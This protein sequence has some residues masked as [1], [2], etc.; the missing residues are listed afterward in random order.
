M[1]SAKAALKA[2]KAA[3]ENSSFHEAEV[4]SR[5]VLN[6]D[7]QNY[8]ATVFLGRAL[9][10]QVKLQ[11]ATEAYECATRIKPGDELAWK[12]LC[13]A[14]ESQGS[15]NVDRHT[16]ASMSLARIY[17]QNE[18]T[19][20]CQTVINHIVSVAQEHGTRQQ[21]KEALR[22]NLPASPV[23]N[24]LEG[25]IPHPSHTF[26]RLIEITEADEKDI[27]NREVGERRTR[28]GAKLGQVQLDV[29]REV[30]RKSELED[31]YQSVIDWTVDD[32]MRSQYEEKLLVH[33]YDFMTVL[34]ADDKTVKQKQ[35]QELARGMVVIKRPFKLAW[36]IELEW[37]DSEE[38]SGLDRNIL[39]E[40]ISFF[41]TTGIA[42][43]LQGFLSQK[44]V[45]K[46]TKEA[47]RDVHESPFQKLNDEEGLL[48][49]DEGISE[50]AKSAF[51]HRLVAEFYLRIEEY[52]SCLDI[53]R[54]G[55][56]LLHSEFEKCGK[57][58]QNSFDSICS[59]LGTSLVYH[60]APK[61]HPEARTIF[62]E[63]LKRKPNHTAALLGIGLIF[64]E[65]EDFD[66]A[67]SFLDRAL[68]RDPLNIRVEVEAA[69]CTALNGQL[70]DGLE[71]LEECNAKLQN[72][73]SSPRD[74]RAQ[75]SYRIGKCLW[76]LHSDRASRK[77]RHGPYS[78]FIASIRANSSYAPAYTSLGLYYKDYG[79]D[80]KRARQCF[81][82]AFESSA[83]ETT[84]AEQ[85]ACT[86]ANDADWDIV[87]IIAQ[88]VIDSGA[89]K[90]MP[91]SR[92]KP[93]SWP[94]AALGI[95]QMNKQEYPLAVRSYQ[96]ALRISPADYHSWVGLGE[97]YLSSGR[98]HAASKALEH[99]RNMEKGDHQSS[100][101]WLASYMHANVHKELGDYAEAIQGYEHIL[102]SQPEDFGV[103][104]ALL[105]TLV[106]EA[107]QALSKGFFHNAASSAKDALLLAADLVQKS[108]K[109]FNF[110]K[111]IGDAFSI[112]M[113]IP[114]LAVEMPLNSCR[115]I[116]HEVAMDDN[117]YLNEL[118][119]IDGISINSLTGPSEETQQFDILSTCL[120]ASIAA[121]KLGICAGAH[122]PHAQAVAWYNLGWAEHQA[123]RFTD[124]I[125]KVK[126]YSQFK[127]CS[128]SAIRCFKRA[129]E[130]EAS[131]AEFWNALGVV[132]TPLN[133]K[134]AQHS[135]V[136]SLHLNERSARTWTDLGTLYLTL[137]DRELAHQAFSRAQSTDPDYIYAWLGEGLVALQLDDAAEARSHFVHAFEIADASAVAAK[138][139][140][141]STLFDQ[142]FA[143]EISRSLG[144]IVTPIFAL[145]QLQ[146]QTEVL[147]PYRHLLS[148]LLERAADYQNAVEHLK[149][150]SDQIET[151]YEESES[152]GV[153]SQFIRLKSDLARNQLAMND[154][155]AASEN[156]HTA[157]DLS[158]DQDET[159]FSTDVRKTT[160]LSAHLTAGMASFYLGS[161]DDAITMFRA[162][163]EESG[164]D[165]DVVCLLAQVLWAKGGSDEKSVAKEQL[166]EVI[167]SNPGHVDATTILGA[168][169]LLDGDHQTHEAIMSDMPSLRTN[170]S[171]K[172]L[173]RKKIDKLFVLS[174]NLSG[175]ENDSR[176]E[177]QRCVMTD[178]SKSLGWSEMSLL[179]GDTSVEETKLVTSVANALQGTRS[180]AGMVAKALAGTGR[181]T[182]AQNAIFLCPW[183][184]GGWNILQNCKES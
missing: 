36:D 145:Q 126:S 106:E 168:L 117:Q 43:V 11:E 57:R 84:A 75:V 174:T 100:N 124:E 4:Q 119:D 133:P 79:K 13:N 58:L 34:L 15:Q 8:F 135:F 90:P 173:Q 170:S 16:V 182:D 31:L 2:A 140:Y 69:W 35:V 60:Q 113:Q 132:T 184:A 32:E 165:L 17:M 138:K 48:L 14:Y 154:Y 134:V 125:S 38:S 25:R 72:D 39:L 114:L 105:Q 112:F 7:P 77:D 40:Y 23:Y 67:S 160:R 148:L 62:N 5:N 101:T 54:K 167:E 131:N 55:L 29:K 53:C 63:L 171:L 82:K 61:N 166:F 98:Y 46:Q 26:L 156:S 110:W 176:S 45:P 155:E 136:R 141:A 163:L 65:Q 183:L 104:I 91:G 143:N 51:A 3:L 175:D 20:K 47:E 6:D 9:E 41:P 71:R 59:C 152:L 102:T 146:N 80:L 12:G 179:E 78:S 107:T 64:A 108:K 118:N 27:I 19:E 85:L 18:D 172:D 129:I 180:D 158:Q 109:I 116:F 56:K 74:L 87:E 37:Q 123:S 103:S 150:L 42:R 128:T 44:Y 10:K 164:G 76:D 169:S 115:T 147:L 66:K 177:I 30:Y 157:L 96:A 153:L 81:Q 181:P 94:F 97:S 122:D 120:K 178:P 99:A 1:A 22:T 93:I 111:A 162:A 24:F 127:T 92:K 121:Q 83:S 88:R 149:A 139:Y 21:Y 142:L 50:S 52:E 33:A 73:K 49:I 68:S 95:V 89:V 130:L 28:L 144:D 86:F 151:L 161:M 159:S 137:D 70:K